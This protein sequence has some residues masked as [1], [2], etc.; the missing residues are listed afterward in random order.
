MDTLIRT[1]FP[2]ANTRPA[3]H[4][5]FQPRHD[6]E[7]NKIV[8]RNSSSTVFRTPSF[9]HNSS[10][11]SRHISSIQSAMGSSASKVAGKAGATAARR[12]YPSTSSILNSTPSTTNAASTPPA[13][14]EVHPHPTTSP[15]AGE[16][17]DHIDLDGRDPQFGSALR[18]IGVA[19]PVS[20]RRPHEDPFPTS[21][22]PMHSGQNIF[23]SSKNNPALML[24]QARQKI[25]SQ[26][27]FESENRGRPSFA[28]RT[29]LT[30]KD[31]NEALR[32]RDEAG[33]PSQ[34]IEKQMRLKPG[35]L[36]QLVAKGT[37]ANA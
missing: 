12:Q 34:E 3:S 30:A 36:D 35:V 24:V 16:K 11:A 31:I 2:L 26:W 32:L 23:P 4:D 33:R 15:P 6:F 22:Q 28:G 8:D 19:P 25:S 29:L 13:S 20:E 18:K 17:S 37:F 7:Q 21:S 10:S 1:Q 9:E 27:D 14:A 5:A